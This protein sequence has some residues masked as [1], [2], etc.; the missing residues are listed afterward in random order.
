[1]L[2]ISSD[3]VG[4]ALA[5]A[6]DEAVITGPG[7]NGCVRRGSNVV[8]DKLAVDT[9]AAT[10]A[11]TDDETEEV[12]DE[13]AVAAPDGDASS[14]IAIVGLTPTRAWSWSWSWAVCLKNGKTEA[15]D[16]LAAVDGDASSTMPVES[17]EPTDSWPRAEP[18]NNK[19]ML[20]PGELT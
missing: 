19:V 9:A 13:L 11:A 16:E 18:A 12:I 10:V 1:M 3:D 8:D 5:M 2:A 15:D 20:T 17:S 6:E 7:V 4:D 14:S